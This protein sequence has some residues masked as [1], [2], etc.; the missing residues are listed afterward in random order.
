MPYRGTELNLPQQSLPEGSDIL[1]REGGGN[2]RDPAA[3]R[4]GLEKGDSD[5]VE[6]E[7]M[8][9]IQEGEE[10]LVEGGWGRLSSP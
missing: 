9:F 2:Q 10:M 3:Q 1:D 4:R 8:V 5:R 6:L 7:H